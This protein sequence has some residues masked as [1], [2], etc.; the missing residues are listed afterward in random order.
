MAVNNTQESLLYNR[1]HLGLLLV[2]SL[3]DRLP[4]MVGVGGCG[5]SPRSS[6]AVMMLS[7]RETGCV[8]SEWVKAQRANWESYSDLGLHRLQGS[9]RGCRV[10]TPSLQ[11]STGLVTPDHPPHRAAQHGDEKRIISGK[12][13]PSRTDVRLHALGGEEDKRWSTDVVSANRCWRDGN[14]RFY[15]TFEEK[16]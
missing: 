2:S 15:V 13:R 5:A 3:S 9:C 6:T 16:N 11:R 4:V 1:Q 8:Q 10:W 12:D 14:D 7:Y